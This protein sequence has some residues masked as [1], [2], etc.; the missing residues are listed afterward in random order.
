MT[1]PWS[2]DMR[3]MPGMCGRLSW[4][5]LFVVIGSCSGDRE[6]SGR[7]FH[8]LPALGARLLVLAPHPDDEVLGAAAMIAAAVRSG[9]DVRVVVA[10]DGEVGSDK[11]GVGNE[12]PHQR[13][14]ET[15]HALADL[16]VDAG[17]ITF[18]GYADG[19]LAGAWSERW[20]AWK[21]NE[22]QGSAGEIVEDL[23]AALRAAA[24]DA[25]VLPMCLDGHPD[26]A[27]LNR[28]ALLAVLAELSNETEPVLLGYLIHGGRRWPASRR[29]PMASEPPPEG[30]AGTLFPWTAMVLDG[31]AVRRKAALIA[32]YQSQVASGS[33]LFR[34]AG[35]EEP[36]SIGQVIHGPRSMSP[37]RP[38][39]R[40]AGR[41][42]AIR[43]PRGDC[44]IDAGLEGRLR[45][46]FMRAGKVEERLV[47]LQG[48]VPSTRGG[49][50]GQSLAGERDVRVATGMRSVRL[51]LALDAFRDI[52]GAVLEVLP[53]SPERV[54]PAWL[55]VW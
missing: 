23:R 19:S 14:D 15:R 51:V 25:V 36:F 9:A 10:T 55:L 41:R 31:S 40:R 29:D 32:E 37:T 12:L 13:R 33:R 52:P 6:M 50:P 2:M 28:F 18:L 4:L 38:G 17:A 43:V 42:I 45:L 46:R 8:A 11:L 7:P 48:G 35:R 39:L 34:Y 22:G 5:L 49:T 47:Q 54:G 26:H 20:L 21:Q 53:P 44:V 1:G 3:W 30:C 16:G 27:A 24:P